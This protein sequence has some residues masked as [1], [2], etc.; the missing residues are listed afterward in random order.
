[1]RTAT[2]FRLLVPAVALLAAACTDQIDPFEPESPPTADGG[3]SERGDLASTPNQTQWADGYLRSG[4]SS[5]DS[6]TPGPYSSFNRT[7]RFGGPITITRVAGTTGRYVATFPR[8][9]GYLGGKSTVHVSGYGGYDNDR[10]YCK[11]VSAYLSS[12]KVE[13]RCFNPSTGL[14]ANT[15]FSLLVTRSYSDLAFAYANQ[16]T[17]ASY[18]PSSQGS[19]NPAGAIN[20]ARRGVGQYRVTFDN[21]GTQIPPNILGHVQVNAVGTSNAY[22]NPYYWGTD[23]SP[24][25]YVDVRCYAAPTGAPVDRRFTVLFLLPADHLAYAWAYDPTAPSYSPLEPYSSNPYRTPTNITRRGVGLY[26][27]EWTAVNNVLFKLGNVQ[28][29]AYGSN[30]VC[31]VS[32]TFETGAYVQCFAPNGTPVDS[33]YS[34]LL[35]S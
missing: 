19:S 1:M 32:Y 6:Y 25:L 28:V 10:T 34:V 29:T 18:T 24:N 16:E 8:L 3:G 4:E 13:V 30:A 14:P 33:R 22:C 7:A 27:V 26:T 35:G 20:V 21:L 23:G 17:A 31:K 9:S 12:D 2:A 11:P 15:S 5:A